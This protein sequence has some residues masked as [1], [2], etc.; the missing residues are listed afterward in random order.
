MKEIEEI[1]KEKGK[2]Y[3]R[4]DM[5]MSQIAQIWGAMLGKTISTNQV[6]MMMVAFKAVRGCNNPDHK[7]S[8]LDAMGYSKIGFDILKDDL[9]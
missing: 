3:G 9:I 7:D 1:I 6:V 8:F 2:T 4:A 5:F